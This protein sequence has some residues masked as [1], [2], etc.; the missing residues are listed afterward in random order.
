MSWYKVSD[1]LAFHAK[2]LRAGN[3]AVGAW[4]RA[5]AWCSAPENLTDGFI[6]P[7]VA[8]QIAKPRVWALL[9]EAGLTEAAADGRP[10]EQ[11]HDYL[12]YNPSA[13]KVRAERAAWAERQRRSR[14][15]VSHAVTSPVTTPVSVPRPVPVP[16]PVPKDPDHTHT[17]ADHGDELGQGAVDADPASLP[18]PAPAEDLISLLHAYAD[19][20]HA[21][22]CQ[23]RDQLLSQGGRLTQGQRQ[24]LKK[25]RDEL[26]AKAAAPAPVPR[27]KALSPEAAAVLAE[28]RASRRLHGAPVHD[29]PAVGIEAW[30]CEQIAAA[31]A[32]VAA[33]EQRRDSATRW[34]AQAVAIEWIEHHCGPRAPDRVIRGEHALKDL[35]HEVGG[36]ELR[37]ARPARSAQERLQARTTSPVAATLPVAVTPPQ[38]PAVEAEEAHRQLE[39]LRGLSMRLDAAPA[40]RNA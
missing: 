18:A 39:A 29:I 31:A 26:A 17:G 38:D 8:R 16:V 2:A 25:R 40:R 34:T 7:E 1:G 19:A 28:Y 15:G 5:G 23:V 21:W 11:I 32:A 22:S 30:A 12:R 37:G 24:T 35:V 33:Q 9:R 13:E 3:E 27:G 20:G 14:G 4:V 6:P 10:G 36:Y